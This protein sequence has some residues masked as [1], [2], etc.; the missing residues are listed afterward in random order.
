[1]IYKVRDTAK[2]KFIQSSKSFFSLVFVNSFNVEI[3]SNLK[4]KFNEETVKCGFSLHLT[5][6]I[7]TRINVAM[8]FKVFVLQQVVTH[9]KAFYLTPPDYT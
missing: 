9:F 5:S 1:M 2:K 8:P 4:K 7:L 6:E 3:F